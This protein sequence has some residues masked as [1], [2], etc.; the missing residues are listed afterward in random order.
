[1]TMSAEQRRQINRQNASKSTGPKSDEGKA[2]SR[3]NALQHGLRAEALDLPNEIP[4]ASEA[5][6]DDWHGYYRPDSPGEAALIDRAVHATIQLRRCAVFQV[7]AVSQQ[8]REAEEN[9]DQRQAVELAELDLLL[10]GHSPDLAVPGFKHSAAGCAYL[11]NEWAPLLDALE[12][13]GRW[14]PAE[15]DRALRLCGQLPDSFEGGPLA[16]LVRYFNLYSH[17][18]PNPELAAFLDDPKRIPPSLRGTFGAARPEVSESRAALR[19]LVLNEV[20]ALESRRTRL[21]ALADADRAGATDRA[22]LL[23]GAEGALLLR[24][25]KMHDGI[26]HRAYSALLKGR[27]E[28]AKA[29]EKEEREPASEPIAA[30]IEPKSVAP[31]EP[32]AEAT[33]PASDPDPDPSDAAP[34][35]AKLA[36]LLTLIDDEGIDSDDVKA[37]CAEI[38]GYLFGIAPVVPVRVGLERGAR[39]VHPRA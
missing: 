29:R 7:E 13:A 2:R 4:G 25:E 36:R 33:A 11:R 22:V 8:V 27:K 6:A 10:W 23:G 1:M 38:E 32:N 20:E 12:G 31:N 18:H 34:N 17:A 3:R 15:R 35:E 19:E 9:W 37:S 5:L 24:Y 14:G 26:F 30:P 16:Y 28:K 21:Q 39:D